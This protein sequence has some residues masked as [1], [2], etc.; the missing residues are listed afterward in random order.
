MPEI[1]DAWKKPETTPLDFILVGAGA[2][3]A[4]LAARLAERGYTVLVAEMGPDRPEKPADAVVEN[5]DVP[6]LH[7]EVTEDPRHALRYFVKHFDSDPKDSL[8]PKL[9]PPKPHDTDPPADEHGIFYPRAQ[10]LGGCTVHN[11]MITVSGPSEDWDQVA[12]ATGD[13]S[14]RGER[15]RAYFQ[16]V[17]R[18]HYN[19]PSRFRK[20]LKYLGVPTGWEGDRHG[21]R[22]WLDTT[23]ADLRLLF[24][25]PRFLK[26]VLGAAVGSL[27][28]GVETVRDLIKWSWLTDR[29]LP[30]LDP[31][32]W[33]TMR[34]SA[35]GL[36]RIPCAIT[37]DG[38]RS[39]ARARLL[40]VK[41]HPQHGQRLHLLTGVC[42]TKIELQDDGA[43][44]TVGGTETTARA[45][46]IQCVRQPHVY[47][48]DPLAG[49]N[50]QTSTSTE[51]IYCKRE[52]ILCGGAFNTPQLLMLSG[53]GEA[54][55]LA[56]HKIPCVRNIPG[57]GKNLQDRYEVPVVATLTGGFRSLAGLGT[58]SRGQVA[59]NDPHLKQ[60]IE[61]DGKPARD[62][63]VYA[64]NGGL[65]GIL[66]RSSQEDAVPDLFIF[67]LAGYFPGYHVGYSK[68]AAFVRQIS[69]AE[70]AT[71]LKPEEQAAQDAAAAAASKQTVTW[72]ILKARTR[73]HS[74]EVR[75][76]SNDPFKRPDINFRSFPE[77]DSDPDVLALTEGVRFVERFLDAGIRTGTVASHE[78]PGLK[79]NDF[80]GNLSK[81]V[82]SVAWGHH[83]CGT[84][85]IGSDADAGAVLD[86]R[87]RVRGVQG[88]RVVD[89][90][91][92]PRIP[93]VFIVTNVYMVAEKA[94]DVLTEDHPLDRGSL[95]PEC[96]EALD[97]DPV[98]RS[99]PNY[100][101][102]RVYPAEL[103]A[104]EAALVHKRR[105]VAY[106]PP[107]PT[108]GTA[109]KKR[110]GPPTGP[111]LFC[112]KS[113]EGPP[114]ARADEAA[115]PSDTLGLALSGGGIRSAAF[116]LGVVQSLARSGW[117]RGVDFLSTVSGG[118][119]TGAFLGRFFDQCARRDGLTGAVPD[120]TPGA[121]QER[122]ARDLAD[123]RSA[124]LAWLRRHSNYLSPTGL[125]ETVTNIAGFWRNLVSVYLVLGIFLFA[126]FGVLNAIGYFELRGPFG[127]KIK[128]LVAALTP[129]TGT[130]MDRLG[131]WAVAAEL[132]LWL[133]V[134]PLMLAYWLAS[135]DRPEEFIPPVLVSAALIAAALLLATFSP[136]GLVVLAFAVIWVFTVW[137]AVRRVEGH[138]DALHP[139]R[140]SL[141][142]NRLTMWLAFWLAAVL[143]LAALAVIDGLGRWL[144][145]RMFQGGQTDSYVMGWMMSVGG[146][147]IGLA[148]GLR[149]LIR[150]LAGDSPKDS[151]A[152]V[153]SRPYLIAAVA[154]LVGVV[155]PLTAVAFA[156]HA[157]YELGNAYAQGLLITGVAVIVSLLLGSKP[158][159]PFINRSG[160]L[161]IYGSRLARAFFGAVNPA[162]RTHPDGKNVTHVIPGDD[163]PLSGYA[164]HAAGGP[165]HLI[166]CAVNETVDVASQRGLRDRQAE[167]LAVGPAGMS[168]A[169]E[170]HAL[171]ANG[172]DGPRL[173]PIAELAES[174]PHPFLTWSGR[175]ILVESLALREWVAISGAALGPGMGRRTSFA[176]ALVLT[177]ANIRLGYWWHSGLGSRQRARVPKARGLW[178]WLAGHFVGLFRTQSLLLA[179]LTGRFGGPWERYWHLSDGGHVE[180]TGAYELLRRRVPFV[181]VCDAGHD[182]GH[183][184]TDLARLVR[185]ARVDFGAEVTEV[186][187]AA[188][189]TAAGVPPAD[190][191]RLSV[192][193]PG[194]L[195]APAD[196]RPRKHATLLL[197]RY[198]EAPESRQ[199]D[200]WAARRHTW[201]LYIRA[202]TTGDEP[203]DV[204]NY[205]A[206][207]PDFPNETTFDQV[208][209]EPQWESYRKLGEHIGTDLF[210]PAP[211]G[212]ASCPAS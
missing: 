94:A 103:E 82:R 51:T 77:G 70:A 43:R 20:L 197:C 58:T 167:N 16:R 201:L 52:V 55:Q 188:V 69:I 68:P 117:L 203:A 123:S 23:V 115:L 73:H 144:A 173:K 105:N 81:W 22:G 35:E 135:Q 64:T 143:G 132:A 137:T 74:G 179:E 140:L 9:Y 199:A 120:T 96:R 196:G 87:L 142:R 128:D 190:A 67:A 12:E 84:C 159:V 46:G 192:G 138:H 210:P 53:I 205:A 48:A 169:Q 126:A 193:T 155:P 29:S 209:D 61:S 116:S 100:E 212:G 49:R 106:R 158:G 65:I 97:R 124:P 76:R 170:W 36:V 157:A 129:V 195:L 139:S 153:R 182:P 176:R 111:W 130:L 21:T 57:V 156:V 147:V 45:V 187:A 11:A 107:K 60:W 93:G 110:P 32:H 121:G 109:S 50:G 99:D 165:L 202:T 10:G 75:L 125:G 15:M 189:L 71:T 4:P 42:V 2:G 101:A 3:G 13:E 172:K 174:R 95:P 180:A 27:R 136:L 154:V 207:H 86:S 102:R 18:C 85:R 90:S 145:W 133:N 98:W 31:N 146:G 108:D 161:A 141:A 89:A 66:K 91:V 92:F 24:R 127:A 152:A 28:T 198:P 204:R 112:L 25:D 39:G 175:A 62:R 44:R 26:V 47:E 30:N 14:W 160:P 37:P 19:R 162:R 80:D 7:P 151:A 200:A 113:P 168:V 72:L 134:V 41:E 38:R 79:D 211:D 88:L 181:I 8:D 185:A 78:C 33:R 59:Q 40:A 150:F 171:W 104:A 194:D 83:A 183:Q 164:P 178:P 186:D 54:A 119:Y 63:G 17:E 1:P 5:T 163:V 206:L 177:L 114:A 184:G 131:P 118:G 148:T 6:L 191:A 56:D 122:V 34:T 208:F 149:M 166:N